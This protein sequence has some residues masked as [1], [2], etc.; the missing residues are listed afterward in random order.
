MIPIVVLANEL[1]SGE[2][3]L[4]SEDHRA[5]RD[6]LTPDPVDLIEVMKRAE[7]RASLPVIET[8]DRV[9]WSEQVAD[10]QGIKPAEPQ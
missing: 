7:R 4:L 2:E 6:S 9:V 5:V 8:S 1:T 10:Q 3:L